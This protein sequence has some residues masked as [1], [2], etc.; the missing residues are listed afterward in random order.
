MSWCKCNHSI[1]IYVAVKLC[2]KV[3][4]AR[5]VVEWGKGEETTKNGRRLVL[6]SC[7]FP[8]PPFLSFLSKGCLSFPSSPLPSVLSLSE[9]INIH[10]HIR[11]FC[12]KSLCEPHPDMKCSVT[13]NPFL[14][15]FACLFHFTRWWQKTAFKG[16]IFEGEKSRIM[17]VPFTEEI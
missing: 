16:C 3:E 2:I 7:R 8:C 6:L 17:V 5:E 11:F 12:L 9:S 10:I 15:D 1:S 4:S 13:Q 14:H